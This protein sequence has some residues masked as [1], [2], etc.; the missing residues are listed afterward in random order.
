MMLK[1]SECRDDELGVMGQRG[2]DVC[3][4]VAW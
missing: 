2:L 1:S 3:L 4:S